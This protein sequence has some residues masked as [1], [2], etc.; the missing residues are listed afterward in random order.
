M[1]RILDSKRAHGERSNYGNGAIYVSKLW[2]SKLTNVTEKNFQRVTQ[3]DH[4]EI[5]VRP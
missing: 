5:E 1:G 2:W 3:Y 4:N